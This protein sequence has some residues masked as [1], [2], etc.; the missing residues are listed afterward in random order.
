MLIQV[1][2]GWEQFLNIF[3]YRR[4]RSDL[5]LLILLLGFFVVDPSLPFAPTIE[6]EFHKAVLYSWRQKVLRLGLFVS[7]SS[8]DGSKQSFM[9][10]VKSKD[11]LNLAQEGK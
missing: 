7:L 4:T 11:W 6:T 5:D 2:A 3:F 1:N 8:A 9:L 10:V